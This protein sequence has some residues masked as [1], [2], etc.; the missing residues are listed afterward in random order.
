MDFRRYTENTIIDPKTFYHEL[1]K[2]KDQGYALDNRE[3]N[4]DVSCIAVPVWWPS[5]KVIASLSISGPYF[6]FNPE[7]IPG[8]V[9]GAKSAA[10]EIT[11]KV[12][13]V[14]IGNP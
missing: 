10:E 8:F 4:V 11:A 13:E 12:A 14:G 3:H 6:Y 1:I 5:R 9:K 2:I 7:N